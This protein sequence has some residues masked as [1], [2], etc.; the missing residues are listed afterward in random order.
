MVSQ[1]E[2]VAAESMDIFWSHLDK[3]HL[4]RSVG[5][6]RQLGYSA[7]AV[8]CALSPESYYFPAHEGDR[9]LRP[10]GMDNDTIPVVALMRNQEY[11][12]ETPVV[13]SLQS[14]ALAARRID[15]DTLRHSG[16]ST[17]SSVKGGTNTASV[18]R[19]FLT[20]P[21]STAQI[22]SR[23]TVIFNPDFTRTKLAPMCASAVMHELV[24]VAQ[25]LTEPLWDEKKRLQKELEAYAV[26]AQL[27]D[28]YELSY[29]DA[30]AMA[31]QV[32]LMRTR[33]LG[34]DGY[35]PTREFVDF[36]R[37]DNVLQKIIK[38]DD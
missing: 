25:S 19:A 26:Q 22:E 31:G 9:L 15:A 27:V 6:V 24:H 30:M 36:A 2:V 16:S 35:E 7:A 29:S 32:N 3:G 28:S 14:Q 8:D 23:P 10:T 12:F 20:S 5:L 17:L 33:H 37:Y 21:G 13:H 18:Y 34:P 1:L 38:K 11:E 4:D